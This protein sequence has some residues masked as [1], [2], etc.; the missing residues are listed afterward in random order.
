MGFKVNNGHAFLHPASGLFIGPG[1]S[2][3]EDDPIPPVEENQE[4]GLFNQSLTLE[5][6]TE[7]KASEQKTFLQSL[8]IELGSNEAQRIENYAAWLKAKESEGNVPE[9]VTPESEKGA[10]E[11]GPNSPADSAESGDRG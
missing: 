10:A 4:S 9:P 1:D 6:F 8:S 2:Y 7:L 11:D 3:F 5:Q